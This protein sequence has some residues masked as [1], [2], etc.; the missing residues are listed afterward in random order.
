[1]FAQWLTFPHF[2]YLGKYIPNGNFVERILGLYNM[3]EG[4]LDIYK[5]V[6]PSARASLDTERRKDM[7]ILLLL[8]KRQTHN[9]IHHLLRRHAPTVWTIHPMGRAEK[10]SIAKMDDFSLILDRASLSFDVLSDA[11]LRIITSRRNL[12]V[13]KCYARDRQRPGVNDILRQ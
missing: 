6:D 5:V 13:A 1:M 8:R 10:T 3:N 12:F 7:H 9:R 4:A 2:W 11:D